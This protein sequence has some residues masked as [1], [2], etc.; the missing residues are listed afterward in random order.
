MQGYLK[1]EQAANTELHSIL[2]DYDGAETTLLAY[3]VLAT[4]DD[5]VVYA[6]TV[7][8]AEQV[9]VDC[10]AVI[11]ST[12]TGETRC[13]T[14]TAQAVKDSKGALWIAEA[15]HEATFC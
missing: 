14:R 10:V 1:I 11:H 7:D 12:I 9:E 4:A 6:D 3:Y 2:T 8:A 13:Y 15:L 5:D